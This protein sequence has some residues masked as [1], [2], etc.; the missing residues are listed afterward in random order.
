MAIDKENISR[1]QKEMIFFRFRGG[2]F[3]TP[4]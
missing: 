1:K 4:K 2:I 3:G